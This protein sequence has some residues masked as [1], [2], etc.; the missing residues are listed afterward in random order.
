MSSYKVPNKNGVFKVV[1]D[2]DL[3]KVAEQEGPVPTEIAHAAVLAGRKDLIPRL[4]LTLATE[5]R[6]PKLAAAKGLLALGDQESIPLLEA[7]A[8]VETDSISAH[9][10]RLVALRLRGVEQ[11]EQCFMRGDEP[12]MSALV[13]S[14]YNG[15][16]VLGE[17]DARF[18]VAALEAY[19]DKSLKWI[20]KMKTAYWEND[21]GMAVEVL[22]SPSAVQVMKLPHMAETRRK[23]SNLLHR[24]MGLSLKDEDIAEDAR[25]LLEDWEAPAGLTR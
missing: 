20:R 12:E 7:R 4:R 21:V 10:F 2:D 22:S 9:L 18:L 16:L 6:I 24:L 11:V 3:D 19:V 8:K 13:L 5:D 25:R 15:Y 17:A 14:M 23:A 1:T